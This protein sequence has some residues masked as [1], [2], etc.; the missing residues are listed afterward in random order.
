MGA[1]HGLRARR[2]HLET[3]AV[4]IHELPLAL[5]QRPAEWPGARIL[6]RAG[7]RQSDFR[8]APAVNS[9]NDLINVPERSVTLGKPADWPS[10]GWDNEYGHRE[11]AVRAAFRPVVIWS[12]MASSMPSWRPVATAS[13]ATGRKPAGNGAR[14]TNVKWPTFWMPDGPAGLHRYRLRTC[15]ETI[16]MPWNWPVEVNHH[17]ARAYCA[18]C[19]E[20]E[21]VPY[22]LP[23]EAE[24]QAL[25]APGSDRRRPSTL[26]PTR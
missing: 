5:V 6:P 16:A 10:Y 12:A 1:V 23:S 8:R 19:A 26:R 2:I 13:S 9:A 18:W 4:L 7:R 24:H 11:T 25:R 21:G 22:R 17:E 14:S 3:S 20:Q 15:S